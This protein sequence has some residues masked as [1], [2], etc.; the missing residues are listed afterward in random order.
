MGIAAFLL[1]LEYVSFEKSVNG[2]HKDIAKTYR[3]LNEDVKGETWAQI[4]PGWATRAAEKF[5]EIS[6]YCR[7]EDGV[8]QGVVK[9]AGVNNDAFREQNIGYADGNFFTFFSFPV[10]AGDANS[11]KKANTV[12]LN[13][14]TAT[15]YFGSKDPI[16][17][18][19]ELNNQ[20][21]RTIYTVGGIYTFPENS[22]I[23]F[24]MIFS[25][26]TLKNPA[27]LNENGWAE[28][29][30]ISSQYIYTYFKLNDGVNFKEVEKKLTSL[31][32]ELGK[33]ND[34]VVFR[35]QPMQ[36]IHLPQSFS[37]TY[38]TTGNLKYVYILGMIA[39]LILA[40]AWFNYI[41]LSTANALKRAAEVG[42]RKVIGATR[43]SLILQFL[44]ESIIVN[45][46]ALVL[47]VVMVYLLQPTFNSVVGKNLS[48]DAVITSPVWLG[49]ILLLVAGSLITGAYTGY[50]LSAFKPVDTLK[51]KIIK[52]SGGVNLRKGL[53]VAQFAI[54]FALILATVLIFQQLKYMQNKNLGVN[55]GQVLVLRGPEV[56]KDSTYKNRRSSF[57]N[58]LAD[59]SFVNQY[60]LSGSIP[61]NGYNF[62]TAGFTQPGSKTGDELK[63][64][65]FAIIDENYLGTYQIPLAA[66]RNFTT[67]ECAVEWNANSKVLLNEKA[68][69]ALGFANAEDAIKTR[70][71]WDERQLEVIGVVK[72]Y[73]HAGLQRSIDPMIFYPQNNNAFIS[74][75]LSTTD[76]SSSTQ[77][78]EKLFKANFPGNPYEYFFA[79]DNFNKQYVSEQQYSWLFT[80]ASIWAIVIAC[81][82]LF[83]LT[84]FTVESRTRE[85]GIRKVLGASA[86]SI[87]Q[88]ISADFLK[89]VGIAAL[90][91]FP[92]AWFG[93]QQWLEAFA[94][95]T[96]IHIW[97]F[98]LVAFVGMAIALLTI[99]FQAIK[100]A[101]A[102]PVKSLRT[103]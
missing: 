95:R 62:M 56:G 93:M 9:K 91:A 10:I 84:T 97:V 80:I 103:E 48:L 35:L 28:L 4:E 55:T 40:I 76:L 44:G 30:N 31:R 82:G 67:A 38:Q 79:D 26:E 61:G 13:E 33:E 2:F 73:H 66:G 89:L 64:Y 32:K 7:F 27:N 5:P 50:S 69:H 6:D 22:D 29:T 53:V 101:I 63:S 85:V 98:L 34:G 88:L 43:G 78:L 16:G 21:G 70:I 39:L 83:G 57:M 90:I 94:Y 58:A 51:G 18:Q 99:S 19:L 74:I 92:V 102:N 87:T 59:Q 12:F 25:L 36:F 14:A 47:A 68:V 23:R 3:L 65:A 15:K 20:F 46:L 45:M 81:L 24:E 86:F 1:L 71:Q 52:S 77:K 72:E 60:S 37:D 8:A 42:V 11:L 49:G 75:R 100:A 41:N 96:P 17:Q 54:S